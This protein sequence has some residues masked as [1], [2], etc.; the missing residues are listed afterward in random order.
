MSNEMT[1]WEEEL[2]AA[3]EA[4]AEAAKGAPAS[5]FF[6]LQ[7]GVLSYNGE[8]VKGN[9]MKVVVL[10]AKYG[11]QYY[12]KPWTPGAAEAPD[13]VSFCDDYETAAKVGGKPW[14]E[15]EE[16]QSAGCDSCPHFQWGSAQTGK[17]KACKLFVRLALL[18]ADALVSADE[19]EVA[20][21][22]VIRIPT[23]SVSN[24]ND[25]VKGLAANVAR[26]PWAVTTM[27]SV[28]PDPKSQF[29]VHFKPAEK[30]PQ[31]VVQA[32]ME[33][34]KRYLASG[35]LTYIGSNDE[36]EAETKVS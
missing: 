15:I 26:P 24:Y 34:R 5:G 2:A 20:E 9:A 29:R 11:S 22:G 13:C 4:E 10:A 16:P 30:L 18:P 27:L 28:A 32:L 23:M 17:G 33:K 3:A 31:P 8:P 14:H 21:I 12:S 7:G 35:A 1:T 25:Y 19:I 6:S 36:E